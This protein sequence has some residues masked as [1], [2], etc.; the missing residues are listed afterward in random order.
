RGGAGT[1]RR[2]LAAAAGARARPARPRAAGARRS[3]PDGL[4]VLVDA[5]VANAVNRRGAAD[6]DR[7]EVGRRALEAV[8]HVSEHETVIDGLRSGRRRDVLGGEGHRV[9]RRRGEAARERVGADEATV[10]LEA[11]CLE[12][13]EARELLVRAAGVQREDPVGEVAVVV[14]GA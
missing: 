12:R 6:L 11:R 3:A 5:L 14:E 2:P 9:A 8:V 1:R 4:V 10:L 7:S 13:R